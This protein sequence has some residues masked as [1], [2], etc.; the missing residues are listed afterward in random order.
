MRITRF[1]RDENGTV[2]V[3]MAAAMV[4]LIGMAALAVDVGMMYLA[5]NRLT[6]TIDAAVLA[7]AHDL[8]DDPLGALQKA[9]AYV[10]LNGV[11]GT[12]ADFRIGTDGK[13]ISGTGNVNLQLFFARVLGFNTQLIDASS[14]ARI[15]AVSSARNIV[16]FGVGDHPYTYGQA[17]QIKYSNGDYLTPG[18]YG[19]LA[20]GGSG[21]STYESNITNGYS[22]TIK[23]G[24]ILPVETGVMAGPTKQGI[25]A[26]INACT[27]SPQ[28]TIDHYVEGCPRILVVPLGYNTPGTGSNVD[29]VVTAFAAF[30]I[31]DSNNNGNSGDVSGKFIQYIVPGETSPTATD[32]GVYTAQLYDPSV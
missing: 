4:A 8:P 22:G 6:N 23:I 29:F 11:A 16:P 26:R 28:C 18:W 15:G 27:H 7:G 5:K 32:R 20:L 2:T 25:Q 3:L 17:V 10:Q 30:L 21:A 19:A 24:D 1:L 31:D 14:F 13:S 9:Q 12:T